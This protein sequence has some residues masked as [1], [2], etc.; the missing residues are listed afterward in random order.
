[1]RFPQGFSARLHLWTV[2]L[3][4]QRAGA[5]QPAQS[6]LCTSLWP[7]LC[8]GRRTVPEKANDASLDAMLIERQL[9]EL[10]EDEELSYEEEHASDG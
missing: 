3:G 10:A 5:R 1:M 6:V 2:T 9:W 7:R 8:S 4:T